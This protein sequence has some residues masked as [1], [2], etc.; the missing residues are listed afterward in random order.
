MV[1]RSAILFGLA[2]LV[3][4][5]CSGGD[6][7]SVGPP[8]EIRVALPSDLRGTNPGVTRDAFTDDV[9]IHI[10]E[11][12]VAYRADQ[13][14]APHLIDS[15]ERSQDGLEYTFHLRDDVVFHNG[16]RMTAQHVVWSWQ[17]M[18]DPETG[19]ICRVWYD[20]SQGLKLESVEA[21][22]EHRVR[23]VLNRP[24]VT[25]L[26]R[27]ANVQCHAVVLHPDSVAEDGTWSKPIG[28]GPYRLLEWNRGKDVLLERHDA[29][30]PRSEPRN[31]LSGARDPIA[32]Y[33]RW[34]IIPDP[35]AAKAALFSGQVDLAYRAQP[36]DLVDLQANAAIDV[37]TGESLDWNVLLINTA[38]PPFSDKDMRIAIAAAINY[39]ALAQIV[40]N[41]ISQ[42]NPSIIARGSSFHDAC[43]SEGPETGADIVRTHLDRAG[44]SGEPITIRTNK[45]FSN[46][47]DNALIIQAMLD[48]YGIKTRL[49]VVEWTTQLDQYLRGDFE[50]MSFGYTGRTDP[51]LAY[52]A[53]L[54]DKSK[55]AFY[56]WDNDAAL[57]L[58]D[59]S[60]TEPDPTA[61]ADLF[62]QIHRL[63]LEDVPIL[64]LF[65][66]YVIDA[67]SSRI[68]G[69]EALPSQK[70]R[71]WG[72]SIVQPSE[73][74][75]G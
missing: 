20:G 73:E 69:Y 67:S 56:Q 43:Q 30:V 24:D 41:G 26:S 5:A 70:P 13:S 11:P 65:N 16:E 66:H 34:R 8:D 44:Y 62:C 38:E 51:V 36:A 21:L 50:L 53:V 61:R 64:N 46:M 72:V 60:A 25:F 27:L 47:Y 33:I 45:R 39:K 28:T 37:H 42:P 4:A 75:E 54:G 63:M 49:E 1:A 31:G 68:A 2:G 6:S 55:N 74:R 15:V 19:W 7:A 48:E 18:L 17:R 10:V 22:D 14:V 32:R 59:E 29:Y 58:L 35:A 3:L 71:L 57:A 12:L 40:S 52:Q 9:M 23:M